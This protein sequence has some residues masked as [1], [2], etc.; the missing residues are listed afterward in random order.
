[1][2]KTLTDRTLAMAGLFQSV[3][4]VAQSARRG[5]ID[6][7]PCETIINS[8]FI[9]DADTTADVYGDVTAL[10]SGL[11]IMVK[12]LGS[13][14]EPAEAELMRYVVALLSL[15]RKLAKRRDL[16]NTIAESLQN[17]ERQRQHF[18]TTHETIIA[19]LA[20]IYSQTIS[21]LTPR[22]LVTGEHG[23]LQNPD[24]ANRVRA[25]LLG[26]I[27]SAVLWSQSGG[28]R[29]QLLFWRKPLVAEAQALLK[30]ISH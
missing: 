10:R 17:T 29:L 16:L 21:T 26:G 5:I 2:S 18:H 6:Q 9:L 19:A 27:R 13:K 14:I 22:I 23:H 4:L 15:E 12:Q 11:Q 3:A 30:K 20:E 28:S 7:A 1:M 25:L 8:L 24:I